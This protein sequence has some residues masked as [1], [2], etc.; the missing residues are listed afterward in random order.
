MFWVFPAG[1]RGLGSDTVVRTQ[2]TSPLK[3]LDVNQ[4]ILPS[5][6]VPIATWTDTAHLAARVSIKRT[7][8]RV[9]RRSHRQPDRIAR[10][11]RAIGHSHHTDRL[12]EETHRPGFGP[13]QQVLHVF[14]RLRPKRPT[15]ESR[16]SHAVQ[17]ETAFRPGPGL[18]PL[19]LCR[20]SHYSPPAVC[21]PDRAALRV[22]G[23][24]SPPS[25]ARLFN[26]RAACNRT[27]CSRPLR[28]RSTRRLTRGEPS[29]RMVRPST[30]AVSC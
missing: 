4:K 28:V 18:T 7:Q 17:V 2:T 15:G 13:R 21:R 29:Y 14:K 25:C 16:K 12:R 27:V 10:H 22:M 6:R 5:V 23:T 26:S 30:A 24:S 8:T 3:H 1:W 20:S 19:A 11:S 9:S